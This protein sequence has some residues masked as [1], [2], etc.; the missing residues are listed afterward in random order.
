MIPLWTEKHL[1]EAIT[2]Q[3]GFDL[4][5]RERLDGEIPIVS[6]SGITGYHAKAKC[7]GPGVVTGRYGTLGEVFYI[8]GSYWP[9][10]TTLWVKDFKGNDPRFVSFLLKTLNLGNQNAAGAVPGVNRNALHLL[11]VKLPAIQLQQRI[12]AI[13][14]KYEDLIE[15]NTRRIQI[16]E[17]M[18]QML[19]REWFVNFRF[20]GHEKVKMVE[21][22]LG[23]IPEGWQVK[24]FG[25]VADVTMGLSPKG[26]TYN[27]DELGVPLIN[28][29][30][31]FGEKFAKAVKW[32]TAP[33]KLCKEGD[34]I[35]CVR[36]STTGRYVKSDASYCLGRGVCAISGEYQCF[37]DLLFQNQ[38]PTLLAQTSGSTFPSWTGPQLKSHPVLCPCAELL[39]FFEKLA[40]P[41]SEAI[42][43]LSKQIQNLRITRDLLLPKL[44]SGEISVERIEEEVVTQLA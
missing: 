5:E 43:V 16:M 6:S 38:L 23:L 26:D 39:R 1:G 12:A 25:V 9:L 37:V 31:E 3:R 34:L 35:V 33:T 2:L 41:L 8:K 42:L 21:S 36:G 20:P 19:Y 30:V 18:A 32:T 4:P 27:K 29:P 40:R 11:P 10:N 7:N 24:P 44:V 17:Q 14:S 22:E 15:N 13:L 28:G